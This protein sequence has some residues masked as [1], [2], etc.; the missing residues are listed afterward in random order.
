MR[1]KT[2]L[3]KI[4]HYPRILGYRGAWLAVREAATRHPRRISISIR[5][6]DH[7]VSMRLGTSDPQVF[8]QIFVDAENDFPLAQ[9]PRVIV[10]AGANIGLSSL[11]FAAKYPRAR[12]FAIEPESSNFAILEANVRPYAN[13]V[14]IQA[15]LWSENVELA[16]VDPGL[17]KWGFQTATATATSQASTAGRS[18]GEGK[19]AGITVAR[20]MEDWGIDAID[21]L[22]ID[23]EGSEKELFATASAWIEKVGAI[24]IELHDRLRMGCSRSF[25]AATNAFEFESRQ[26]EKV[27]VAREAGMP[28]R[29][30]RRAA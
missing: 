21:L 5:G 20:L 27:I 15:A 19:V 25:Y 26:G 30:M 17:G 3:R 28:G 1:L 23:I 18:D 16:L 7:P 11:D 24:V 29:R 6:L 9:S 8:E 4:R 13:I 2:L 14:P 10:D 12:I 22:K